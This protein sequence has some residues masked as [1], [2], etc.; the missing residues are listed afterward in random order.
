M[1]DS[2]AFVVSHVTQYFC[3]TLV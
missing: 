3:W 1:S 2:T